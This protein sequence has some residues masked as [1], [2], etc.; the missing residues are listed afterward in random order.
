MSVDIFATIDAVEFPLFN[1]AITHRLP[2]T[3]YQQH[4]RANCTDSVTEESR[5]G[6]ALLS[7]KTPFSASL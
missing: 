7:N 1:L 5:S 4:S 3:A 2:K 6:H